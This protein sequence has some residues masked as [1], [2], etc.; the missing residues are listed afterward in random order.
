MEYFHSSSILRS[1]LILIAKSTLTANLD[2]SYFKI[3]I[4]NMIKVELRTDT[5]R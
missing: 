4:K 3:L 2:V 5:D 1:R